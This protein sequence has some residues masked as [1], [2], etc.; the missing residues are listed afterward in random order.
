MLHL[1]TILRC[2]NG[3][4]RPGHAG[5][6]PFDAM[7]HG[8]LMKDRTLKATVTRTPRELP[9][10]SFPRK[11]IDYCAIDGLALTVHLYHGKVSEAQ[12]WAYPPSQSGRHRKT[13]TDLVGR[14]G[15]ALL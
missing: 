3:E 10:V 8:A 11:M 1:G 14:I 9:V 12:Q 4:D 7:L 2:C 13:G 15:F 5:I 6:S